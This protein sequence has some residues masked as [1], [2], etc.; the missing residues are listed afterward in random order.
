MRLH[1]CIFLDRDGVLNRE[2]GEYTYKVNDFEIIAG[3]KKSLEIL[4]KSGYLLIV[5]TNQAGVAKGLYNREDVLIC[6][7]YLQAETGGLVD[8]IYFCPH[9]PVTTNSLLRKPNSLMLEKAIAKWQVD[10]NKSYMIGD[11]I[12]DIKAAEKIG[13][14]GI[15]VGDKELEDIAAPRAKSLLDAVK[16]FILV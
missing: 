9:H 5:I 6:H 13:V 1:K 8:D 11:S 15:L 2:R 7:A 4:K 14:K 12:R 16:Q 3:V 10:T